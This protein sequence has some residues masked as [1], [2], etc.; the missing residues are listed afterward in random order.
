MRLLEENE[1]KQALLCSGKNN[2]KSGQY[3]G[4]L[5]C[6]EWSERRMNYMNEHSSTHVGRK[7]DAR[8]GG[9]K[10]KRE[11]ERKIE[12]GEPDDVM[13][14]PSPAVRISNYQQLRRC[15]DDNQNSPVNRTSK[16]VQL[17]SNL[18]Q[19]DLMSIRTS[20]TSPTI[21][22]GILCNEHGHNT[23]NNCIVRICEREVC[24]HVPRTFNILQGT[25]SYSTS[26]P[27]VAHLQPLP[28]HQS[29]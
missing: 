20:P 25:V 24:K 22:Y 14:R 5:A 23:H 1:R 21:G 2:K 18:I 12:K 4:R 3:E 28:T 10:N 16:C 13:P 7:R 29:K 9:R 19:T 26:L 15:Y 11:V 17:F 6:F 27:Q 8:E